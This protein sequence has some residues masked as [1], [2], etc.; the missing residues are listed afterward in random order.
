[1]VQ[2]ESTPAK[3]I[4]DN[5]LTGVTDR[6][7]VDVSGKIRAI[8]VSLDITHDFIGDLHVALIA[9][10]GNRVVLHDRTGS[11]NTKL[12]TIYTTQTVPELATLLETDVAGEWKMYVSD[13]S[14]LDTGSFNRWGLELDVLHID[15]AHSSESGVSAIIPDGDR[16]GVA[17]T[18]TLPGGTVIREITVF[19]DITHPAIGDL[20][21]SLVPPSGIPI[22]L[23]DQVGGDNDNLIYTWRSAE[24]PILRAVRGMD[25]GGDWTLFV[26]DLTANNAGKLNRWKIEVMG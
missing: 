22:T 26:A 5:R 8:K 3:K 16:S 4:P 15:S 7:L 25:S 13:R 9:P 17:Q 20:R 21:V 23:H 12:Q 1:M 11:N 2:Y 24:N 14:K 10:N 6:M 19:V 18:L